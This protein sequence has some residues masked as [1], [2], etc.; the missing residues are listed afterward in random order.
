MGRTMADGNQPP[1]PPPAMVY[2]TAPA[3]PAR[4]VGMPPW[5][6]LWDLIGMVI[7]FV[8][9]IVIL[10][11]FLDGNA[12]ANCLSPG[13]GCSASGAAGDIEGFFTWAGVGIFLVVLG[14]LFRVFVGMWR[15]GKSAAPH[16][17]SA[18]PMAP[19][20]MMMTPAPAPAPVAPAPMPAPAPAPV[21]QPGAP[22][23]PACGKPTT[24]IA[25]YGRYYC[26]TDARYV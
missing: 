11:G 21:V 1:P 22:L 18:A 2:Q 5:M 24:Y 15:S 6:N 26:Y 16:A 8:G 23:C 17:V 20:P 13:S 4:G 9:A 7:I 14:W 25:Q 19:A 12:Y 10:I 3:Q